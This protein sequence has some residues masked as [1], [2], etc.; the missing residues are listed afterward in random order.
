MID[1]A[2]IARLG[3]RQDVGHRTYR[4]YRTL[5]QD[6]DGGGKARHF[7]HGVADI[8]DRHARLVA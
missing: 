7:G 5:G 3:E 6:H 4:S 2:T 8:E 1:P